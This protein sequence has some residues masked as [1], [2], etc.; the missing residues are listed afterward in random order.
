MKLIST[1]AI[2]LIMAVS[3]TPAVAQYGSNY[4]SSGS[5]QSQPVSR[6]T[7]PGNQQQPQKQQQPSIKP[8]SKALKALVELQDAVNKN[9][10]ANIPSKVAAAQAVAQTKEDRY[11]IAE[12][13][14][15]AALTANNNAAMAA[16]IDAVAASGYNTPAANSDLYESLGSTFLNAKQYP[17]AVAAFQK[18]A[19]ANP[20]NWHSEALVGEALFQ[21]GQKE[22]AVSAFRRA[23]QLSGTGG[24][25]P[26]ENLYK[27]AVGIAY[28]AKSPAAP[29]LARAWVAAYPSAGS[30]N[31]AIAIY[32]NYNLN[33]AE[34][35]RDLLRLKQAVGT[36]TPGEY[37]L[38][39]QTAA[40]Q[41]VFGEAQSVIEAAVTAKKIDPA[42]PEYHTF[43]Q[44]IRAK[45]KPTAADLATAMKSAA[46]AK[47]LMR[48]GDNY[49]AMGDTANA[50]AA[51][52][53]AATKA[54]GDAAVA[55][56]HAGIAL[57]ESGDKVGATASFNAVTG[58]RA[59][60][61]KY[62]LTYLAQKG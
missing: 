56:L 12:L 14:L 27:R 30:W 44:T 39:A 21:A 7:S 9:D 59:E 16:A 32:R 38:L 2:A 41:L 49:A 15:K 57:A 34:T 6:D 60:I 40:D 36:I 33:D 37:G 42:N 54:D 28:E 10:T 61:A 26:D 46:N 11:L 17:E 43:V 50:V 35:T 51:Y 53:A 23:V 13:Q 58:P 24:T 20:G 22:Q 8:S 5:Q 25:K 48:I 52:K 18:A 55:N 47:A 62:W 1:T 45:A 4:G 19:A 31:D 3:A 29:E